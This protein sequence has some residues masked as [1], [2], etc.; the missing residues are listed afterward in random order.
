MSGA[1]LLSGSQDVSW[2]LDLIVD[3]R[4]VRVLPKL[5]NAV[6]FYMLWGTFDFT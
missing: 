5:Y 1:F 6:L 3:N 2:F 4:Q